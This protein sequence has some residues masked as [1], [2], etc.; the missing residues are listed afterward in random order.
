V[1]FEGE[2]PSP[3]PAENS[4]YDET[5]AML[6]VVMALL[7]LAMELALQRISAIVEG[8]VTQG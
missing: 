7:S 3:P 5:L 4:F 8:R 6:C 2:G 1:I